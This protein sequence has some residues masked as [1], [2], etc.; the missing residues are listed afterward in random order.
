MTRS[1]TREAIG[2]GRA[3]A[4]AAEGMARALDVALAADSPGYH[5]DPA[6]YRTPEQRRDAYRA[7]L[8][9]WDAAKGGGA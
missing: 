9:A 8:A 7:A 4:A 2:R 6:A 1:D 5:L 3:K